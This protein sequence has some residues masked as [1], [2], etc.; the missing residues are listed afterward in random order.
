MSDL[1]P[2]GASIVVEG[3]E[4]HLLFTLNAIDELQDSFNLELGEIVDSLTDKKLSSDTLRRMLAILLNDEAERE[5]QK[6]KKLKKYTVKEIGWVLTLDN[7]TEYALAILKAYG[8]SLPEAEEYD[9]NRMSGQAE[10]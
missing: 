10:G 1:R 4:R 3:E 8:L 9:P 5:A 6:G 2:T 7:Q